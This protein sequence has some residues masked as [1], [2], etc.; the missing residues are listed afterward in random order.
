[1]LPQVHGHGRQHSTRK[2]NFNVELPSLQT[3]GWSQQGTAS[4][5]KP[6]YMSLESS[7]ISENQKSTG[8][9]AL[10]NYSSCQQIT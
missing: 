10:F 2:G 3:V 8:Y 9:I 5:S 7:A 6:Q 1:M 4:T